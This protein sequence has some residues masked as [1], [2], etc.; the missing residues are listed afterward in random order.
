LQLKARKVGVKIYTLAQPNELH[1]HWL[2]Y[3]Y[4]GQWNKAL[5][6]VPQLINVT[7]ELAHYYENMAERLKEG[8]PSDWDGTYRATSK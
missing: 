7:P 4:R 1:D 6:L 2:D 3:Y 5:M 8:V